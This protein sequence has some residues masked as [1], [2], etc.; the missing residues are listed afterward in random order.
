MST[1]AGGSTTKGDMEQDEAGRATQKVS[2]SRPSTYLSKK[3]S[4]NLPDWEITIYTAGWIVGVLY[5]VYNVY[6][7][8]RREE[9]WSN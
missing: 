2:T 9:D 4:P 8:S 5:A 6:L 3:L 7:C 1:A